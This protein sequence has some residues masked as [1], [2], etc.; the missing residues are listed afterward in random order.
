MARWKRAG[1]LFVFALAAAVFAS[2]ALAQESESRGASGDVVAAWCL[3]SETKE[4]YTVTPDGGRETLAVEG[5]A[6]ESAAMERVFDEDLVEAIDGADAL[7]ASFLADVWE[8]VIESIYGPDAF[9]Q[10]IEIVGEE[11][12]NVAGDR[13]KLL[14]APGFATMFRS[15]LDG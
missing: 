13:C 1:L 12:A 8:T 2:T 9:S 15:F 3:D 14:R 5:A 6:G 4:I 10:R 11:T 7:S